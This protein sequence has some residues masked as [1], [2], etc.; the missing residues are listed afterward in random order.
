MEKK[1]IILLAIEDI[2]DSKRRENS[3]R[4][5]SRLKDEYLEII[6]DHALA[7]I[8]IWDSSFDHK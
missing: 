1:K 5:K 6:L 2:T 4:E 7:P 8:I 3:F